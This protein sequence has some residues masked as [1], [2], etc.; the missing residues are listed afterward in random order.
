MSEGIHTPRKYRDVVAALAAKGCCPHEVEPGL[1]LALCPCCIERRRFGLL[2]VRPDGVGDG[3][4]TLEEER[5]HAV[6][7]EALRLKAET[8]IASK[9]P[10]ARRNRKRR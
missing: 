4:L 6:A 2:T 7:I 1:T 5:R 8:L 9:R 10:P 3:A